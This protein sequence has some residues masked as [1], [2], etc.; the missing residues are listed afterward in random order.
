MSFLDDWKEWSTA[1]K[2]ISIILV[3][4][5]G[6]I[7][8]ALI[9]GGLSSDKNTTPNTT[10]DVKDIEITSSGYGG[11]KLTCKVIPDKDYNYLEAQVIF[12]DSDN[13][14]IDK[15]PLVWNMKDIKAN[16][17]IK[18]TGNA[19]VQGDTTPTH[20]KVLFFDS[21]LSTEESNAIFTNDV[22]L[23]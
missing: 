9:G 10:I 20:A 17:T 3:C 15:S 1:K 13:A 14:V 4:C 16:Q 6:L 21:S 5:I 19:Y 8:V 22:K 7:I 12:Y 23:K 11:Y 2:A 18:V